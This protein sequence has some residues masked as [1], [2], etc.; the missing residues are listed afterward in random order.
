MS[1]KIRSGNRMLGVLILLIGGLLLLKE[2]GDFLPYWLFTWPMILI[3]IGLYTGIKNGFQNFGAVILLLVG[4]Y[5][6][7]KDK[8]NLPIEIGPYLLPAALIFLGLYILFRRKKKLDIDWKDWE[9]NYDRWERKIRTGKPGK[10]KSKDD[11]SDFLNVE[12]IFC[13][14]KRKVISKNFQGGEVS[15]VFGGTDIDFLHADIEKQ[16]VINVSV[17]FGGLKL[18][19]PAHWDVQTSL[20]NVAAGVEDKRYVQQG[21]V[22]PDKRLVIAGSVV[23]GGIEIT[24]Y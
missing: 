5:F 1:R 22:D 8:M 20:N 4:G 11:D 12:A 2:M 15:T 17:V 10:E 23:F 16:A 6:L 24:S 3:V 7:L 14:I 21:T 9:G 19:V 13:G 18:L